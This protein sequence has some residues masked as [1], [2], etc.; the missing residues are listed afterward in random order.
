MKH[1]FLLVLYLIPKMSFSQSSESKNIDW[2]NKLSWDQIKIKAKKENKYIF[3]D[4]YTSWCAPCKYMDNKVF[5]NDTVFKFMNNGFIS[6]KLQMDTS[7]TDAP[8]VRDWYTTASYF[9]KAFHVNSYPTFL[10]FDPSGNLVHKDIGARG[11]S[12]FMLLV[13]QAADP[14]KQFFQKIARY[15]SG[16]LGYEQLPQLAI[17]A[18]KIGEESLADT[19][20]NDYLNSYLFAPGNKNPITK[21]A[22][23][24]VFSVYNFISSD[25]KTFHFIYNNSQLIDKIVGKPGQ[26]NN[27][28]D[29]VIK[30]EDIIPLVE[31]AKVKGTEPQWKN[32]IKEVTRKYGESKATQNVIDERIRWY[33]RMGIWSKAIT[34]SIKKVEEFHLDTS[35]DQGI[36]VYNTATM[37]LNHTDNPIQLR[38][39]LQWMKILSLRDDDEIICVGSMDTYAGLLYKTGKSKEGVEKMKSYVNLSKDRTAADILSKM[40]KGEKIW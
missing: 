2:L 34:F 9:D 3:V 5:S 31:T 8:Y 17:F 27:L 10:F 12:S 1:L 11:T 15:R 7:K 40:E 6:I 29:Y 35:R 39:A 19:L 4:C 18:L 37:I 25:S 30:K 24:F 38:K 23:E 21:E 26:A 22:L 28:I 33:A 20:S 32:M 13:N 16:L 14:D 36:M